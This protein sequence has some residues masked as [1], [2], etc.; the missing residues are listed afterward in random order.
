LNT[1]VPA[2]RATS[3]ARLR[4]GLK[5]AV[6]AVSLLLVSP[7]VVLLWLEKR[8][9]RSEALFLLCSQAVAVL[10]GFLGRW[11]RGA[12]YFGTLDRCSW[13]T[14][15]GFGCLFT[16][17]AAVLGSRV[18]MGAYCILGHVDIGDDVMIG[19]R[20][21]IPSGKRQHLDDEGRLTELTRF[22]CVSVGSKC[23]IG[24][25]AIL[26]ASVGMQCIVSAG[27]VVT[28]D[29]P[30]RSVIGGNPARVLR[31]IDQDARPVALD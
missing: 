10:P 3:T 28:K 27:A 23:W 29:M 2:A 24:E 16:H 22:E 7:L 19:S 18:S 26:V 1:I 11:L 31:S 25:G 20:V 5:A 6:F 8:L 30:S 9:L 21:S 12:Y 4:R 14:H 17:R 15:I 13:E